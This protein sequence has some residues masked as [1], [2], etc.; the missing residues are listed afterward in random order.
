LETCD[1]LPASATANMPRFENV[2]LRRRL[3][4][5]DK[6]ALVVGIGLASLFIFFWLVAFVIVGSLGAHHLLA[7]VGLKSLAVLLVIPTGLWSMLRST[8]F[9]IKVGRSRMN[10]LAQHRGSVAAGNLLR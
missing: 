4:W 10:E 3:I 1:E 5:A 7:N 6:F 8:D 9:A 2:T